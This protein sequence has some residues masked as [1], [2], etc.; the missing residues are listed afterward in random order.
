MSDREAFDG[1]LSRW[2][3]LEPD[4]DAMD[5]VNPLYI[6]RNHLV[7]DALDA[8]TFED[9]EPLTRLLEVLRGPAPLA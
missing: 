2:Q 8:A 9:L 6:P 7:E 4:A 3:A 5:R 1:W